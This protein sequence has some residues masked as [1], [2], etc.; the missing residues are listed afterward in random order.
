MLNFPSLY[1]MAAAV[2]TVLELGPAAIEARALEL[3]TQIAAI[4]KRAGGCVGEKTSHIV[5]SRWADRDADSIARSLGE[6]GIMVA[7]RHGNVRV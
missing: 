3:G 4:L 5:A 7:A 6:R 1:G 2:R